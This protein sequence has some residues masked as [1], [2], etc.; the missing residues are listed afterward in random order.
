MDL[1]DAGKEIVFLDVT[2]QPVDYST[3]EKFGWIVGFNKIYIDGTAIMPVETAEQ[4]PQAEHIQQAPEQP[5]YR[6]RYY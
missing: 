1:K 5:L 2:F 4:I 6:E 3:G